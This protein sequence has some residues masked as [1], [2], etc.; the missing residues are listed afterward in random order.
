[1]PALEKVHSMSGAT[2]STQLLIRSLLFM[3][4]S[5]MPILLGGCGD[6]DPQQVLE[7]TVECLSSFEQQVSNQNYSSALDSA[8]EWLV[9]IEGLDKDAFKSE[10]EALP[11]TEQAAIQE[12][13]EAAALR[14]LGLPLV[15]PNYPG[16]TRDH[17]VRAVEISNRLRKR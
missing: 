4:L 6:P 8:E 17:Q 3:C 10:V 12:A 7:K 14:F 2:K 1:V 15:F 9:M 11:F 13:M 16:A 5:A